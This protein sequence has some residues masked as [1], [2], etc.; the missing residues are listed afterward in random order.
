MLVTATDMAVLAGNNSEACWTKY[1]S[2]PLHRPYC[3]EQAIRI[4]LGCLEMNAAR[5]ERCLEPRAK[6]AQPPVHSMQL[7]LT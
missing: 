3:H 6:F 5:C 7:L 2:Y 4:L 1:G